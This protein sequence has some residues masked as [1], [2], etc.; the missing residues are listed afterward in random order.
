MDGRDLMNEIFPNYQ[1]PCHLYEIANK[2][3][4]FIVRDLLFNYLLFIFS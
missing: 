3:P 4:K 2:I 1:S